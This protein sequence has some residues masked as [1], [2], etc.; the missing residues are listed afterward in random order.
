MIPIRG[1]D[2][3]NRASKPRASGDDPC[4][5]RTAHLTRPVNPARA[6]I[7]P[8]R[9]LPTGSAIRKPRASGDD[10]DAFTMALR[11]AE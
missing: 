8:V 1:T 5:S 10:P 7:I 11:A 2:G 4:T 3:P 9:A 6:G